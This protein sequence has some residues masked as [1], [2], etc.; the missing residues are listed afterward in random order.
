[1]ALPD[2]EFKLLLAD[3][4]ESLAATDRRVAGLSLSLTAMRS[5]LRD[6]RS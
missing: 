3:L 5:A 6:V 1:M 4:F 2:T